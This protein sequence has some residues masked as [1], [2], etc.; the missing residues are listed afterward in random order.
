MK[1]LRTSKGPFSERPYYK[2]QEIE[3]IC[4]DALREVGLFPSRPEPVR[5]D[6]FIEKRFGVVPSYEDLPEGVLGLTRFGNNGVQAVVVA[7]ALD[8]DSSAAAERRI[9]TTLAHEGGHGLLHTHLFALA[10]ASQNLF[11]DFSEPTKPKV[12]CRD[13]AATAYSG[14][15]WEFQANMAMAHLLMPRLLVETAMEEFLVPVG[16]FGGRRLSPERREIAIAAL[17]QTF[18]VNGIVARFR[19]DALY[20]GKE[21]GQLAL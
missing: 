9:R 11:G 6:R 10:T 19:V 3:N 17:A 16:N 2:D 14:Q 21:D 5:I 20:P 18:D 13:E 7:K 8:S 1:T 4:G 12:L 15:W